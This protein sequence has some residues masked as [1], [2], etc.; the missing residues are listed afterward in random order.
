MLPVASDGKDE[1]S[2]HTTLDLDDNEDLED[3]G[4]DVEGE[5]EKEV[6]KN[7]YFELDDI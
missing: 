2:G 4:D 1:I 5:E 6:D 3:E 7:D